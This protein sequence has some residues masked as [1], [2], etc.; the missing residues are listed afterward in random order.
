MAPSFMRRGNHVSPTDPLL[1]LL[2]SGPLQ[3]G[4]P[5]GKPAS[6]RLL[7]LALDLLVG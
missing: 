2:H 6:A 4:L 7:P 5:A 3:G 1:L